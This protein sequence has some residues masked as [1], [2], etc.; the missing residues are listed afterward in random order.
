MDDDDRSWPVP[1]VGGTDCAWIS[2]RN[3]GYGFGSSRS[4]AGTSREAHAQ[5]IRGFLAIIDPETAYIVE[6]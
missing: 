1:G 5:S 3:K 4:A 6:D 2:G